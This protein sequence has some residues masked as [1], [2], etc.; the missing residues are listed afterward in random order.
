MIN[1]KLMMFAVAG[2]L[3]PAADAAAEIRAPKTTMIIPHP[4]QDLAPV[5]GT[6]A[7]LRRTNEEQAG[8]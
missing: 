7:R 6:P 3:V 4:A 8:N 2:V 1:Q 5:S